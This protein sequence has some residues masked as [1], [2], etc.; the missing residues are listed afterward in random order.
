MKVRLKVL[1]LFLV[2]AFLLVGAAPGSAAVAPITDQQ[3]QFS[4]PLMVVNTS[5]LNIRTGP[6]V[7]YS[8]LI[9][10]VGGT[11]LPVLGVA[12]DRVWYQVSTVIGI[13]WVNAEFVIP[14]GDFTNVPTVAAPPFSSF[15]TGSTSASNT[16]AIITLPGAG[17]QGGGGAP[18]SSGGGTINA[19]LDANGNPIIVSGA[20][21]RFRALIN[22]EAVDLRDAPNGSRITTLFRTENVDYP[23]V[24][25]ARDRDG[26][27]W[28]AIA[29]PAGTGWVEAPKL[30]IRLSAACRTVLVVTA[31][32]LAFGD[33]GI[34]LTSGDEGF[35]VNITQDG[36][37]I[38]M[39]LG[40]G[41]VN[42][43]PFESV[44]TRTGTTTDGLDVNCGAV[45]PATGTGGD[46]GG[47]GVNPAAPRLAGSR[48]IVNTAFLNVRSGP[49]A[50]YIPVATVPGGTELAVLGIAS[51]RVW[52]LVE[53]TFGRGWVNQDFTIFRGVINN[54]P[55]IELSAVTGIVATPQ[56]VIS[57][58]V[59]LYVA[60]G[61]NFSAVGTVTGPIE[62]PAV[63]RTA[64]SNW[65][66]INTNLGFGW[67]LASQVVLRGDISLI[68][69]VR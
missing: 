25:T 53:G 47:G 37:N 22:V 60:P 44:A 49:G 7:N 45:A 10:V 33:T 24:G 48:V 27:E 68:P 66:Q 30:R 17:D 8:V 39:E 20:N 55:V 18:Q 3:A 46:Q 36:R 12:N 34:I 26:V 16:P 54:V 59:T 41:E 35:L 9:T 23:I 29:T 51:D 14:R 1:S 62:V 64:D 38:Q 15:G 11:E 5:F 57:G 28:Y 56:A 32:T 4:A 58:S 65:I 42:F 61:T 63:A 43:V 21:E 31:S 50:Q 2:C 13:G 52:F 67:V 19:G 6:G 69:V 40:G